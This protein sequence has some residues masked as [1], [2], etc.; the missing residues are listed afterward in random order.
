MLAVPGLRQDGSSISIEFTIAP[1]LD[2]N[3]QVAGL[4][5]V[6]RDVTKAFEQIRALR[7]EVESSK[8]AR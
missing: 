5:S 1:M 6:I 7:K 8:S 2:D 3:N 4:V